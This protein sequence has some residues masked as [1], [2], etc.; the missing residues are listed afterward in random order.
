MNRTQ[1]FQSGKLCQEIYLQWDQ[2]LPIALLRIRSSP[3]KSMGLSPFKNLFGSPSSLV[4]GLQGGLKQMGDL[5]LIQKMQALRLTL[6]K[7][8][9][10]IR[11]RLSVS[12][13]TPTQ[14]CKPGDAVWVKEWD[15]Q[16][17]QPHWKGPYVLFLS[18]PTTV[19]ITEIISWIYH[20][21]VAHCSHTGTPDHCRKAEP[22]F[23]QTTGDKK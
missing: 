12:L 9:D 8:N 10:W 20:S 11:E 5:S 4:K 21:R 17:L 15:V 16:L 22:C 23:Q 19:K 14:T 7:I 6:S 1:K 18:T 2:L 3:I 13:T